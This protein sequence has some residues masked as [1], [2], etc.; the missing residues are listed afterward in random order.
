VSPDLRD[1]AVG[2]LVEPALKHHDRERFVVHCYS[3]VTA[4]DARTERFRGYASAWRDIASMP[5]DAVAEMIR[6]DE[7]DILVDELPAQK[8]QPEPQK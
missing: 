5:D 3:D 7:I 8:A 6:R 1:H 2:R 4:P